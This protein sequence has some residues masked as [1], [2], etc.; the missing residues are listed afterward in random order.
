M[1]RTGIRRVVLSSATAFSLITLG[2]AV[3]AAAPTLTAD[4]REE[5]TI[6]L[7]SNPEGEAWNC[8]L[9]GSAAQAGMRVDMAATGESRGGF[10]P[11]S[12]VAAMCAGPGIAS[13]TGVTSL[14]DAD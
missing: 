6:A 12:T 1:F 4:D 8:L 14:D 10:A 3:A 2:G 7:G 13:T 9:I 5:G 11:A